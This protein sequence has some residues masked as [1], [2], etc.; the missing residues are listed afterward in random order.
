M[1]GGGIRP[2]NKYLLVVLAAMDAIILL[3]LFH[4]FGLRNALL[5]TLFAAPVLSLGCS[6]LLSGSFFHWVYFT[7]IILCVLAHILA[8]RLH[9]HIKQ[10]F[11]SSGP[12]LPSV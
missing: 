12:G 9:A 2:P 8:T 1:G 6:Y 7:L 4:F 10:R 5:I 3:V 11:P